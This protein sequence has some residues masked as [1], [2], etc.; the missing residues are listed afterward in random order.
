MRLVYT[1]EA[2]A[3]LERLR[4]FIDVHNPSAAN[5]IAAE[6][7]EKIQLLKDFPGMGAP[8]GMAPMPDTVRD[9]V[10]GRYVVRYSTHPS[11]IIILRIW[12]GTAF[13]PR[14]PRCPV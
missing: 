12:H 9:M 3:D 4:A 11:G 8:V 7:V 5:R 13:P 1:D 14:S 6:L 10:F 2:I